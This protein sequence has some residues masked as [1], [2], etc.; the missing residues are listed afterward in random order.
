MA[1]S[2][3]RCVVRRGAIDQQGLGRAAD[4][5]AP[6]LGVHHDGL[7]HVER[8]RLVDV[9]VADAF[10]MREHRHARLALHARDQAFAAAR[11]DDVDIAVE[12]LQHH[13]DR[14]AVAGRNQRDRGLRQIGFAQPFGQSGMDGARRAMAVGAAAQDHG[15]AGLQ[16][17]RAG[18][19]G[20][21]GPAFVDHADD[22]ERHLDALDGHAVRPRPGFGDPADRIGKAA[23][24][25]EAFGHRLDALVVQ[26]RAGRAW[27]RSGRRS[28]RRPDPRRWRRGSRICWREWPTPWRRA[29]D[30]SAPSRRAPAPGRRPWR[31]ARCRSW[32]RRYRSIPR[33]FSAARSLSVSYARSGDYTTF[34]HVHAGFSPAT[35]RADRSPAGV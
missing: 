27:R 23:H 35:G 31:A 30:P 17:Q 5:G 2:G 33:W 24:H 28:C 16:G 11:H 6:Q 22:A 25:V 10:E 3:C 34:Y 21:V 14:A 29:R 9:D 12:A 1:I 20:D 4:A 26:G 19:G 15:V 13:A 18:V 7:G 8:R 32:S